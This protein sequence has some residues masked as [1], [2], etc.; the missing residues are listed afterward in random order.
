[1]CHNSITSVI[2]AAVW[3]S[4]STA[5]YRLNS[6]VIRC[7]PGGRSE[8]S[9]GVSLT[10]TAISSVAAAATKLAGRYQFTIV[11][12]VPVKVTADGEGGTDGHWHWCAVIGCWYVSL[13]FSSSYTVAYRRME[14][15]KLHDANK[16]YM[17][18][19]S[20]SV[21]LLLVLITGVYS[22]CISLISIGTEHI[23]CI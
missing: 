19:Y 17:R 12:V 3:I 4:A 11:Y 9:T 23:P 8:P 21:H 18:A 5:T 15:L 7:H 16:A 14:W 2:S 1:M 22:H 13:I 6:S 20:R 10:Q